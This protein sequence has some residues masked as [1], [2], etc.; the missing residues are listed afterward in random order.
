M[1]DIVHQRS[2][3]LNTLAAAWFYFYLGVKYSEVTK[4]S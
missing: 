3:Y 4:S 1:S 2:R